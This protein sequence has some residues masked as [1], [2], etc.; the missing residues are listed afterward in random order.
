M[1][2]ENPSN[3][4]SLQIISSGRSELATGLVRTAS[5]TAPATQVQVGLF[6]R[7]VIYST[8]I[9]ERIL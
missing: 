2:D 4:V 7:L 3:F 1:L 8:I 5:A 6:F 9:K